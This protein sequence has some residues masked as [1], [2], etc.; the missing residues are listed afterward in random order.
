MASRRTGA[1]VGALALGLALAPT[2]TGASAHAENTAPASGL[3]PLLRDMD[4][5]AVAGVAR[6]VDLASMAWPGRVAVTSYSVSEPAHGS[7]VGNCASGACTYVPDEGHLGADEL[8]VTATNAAGTSLPATLRLTTRPN[9]PPT[10][11][12]DRRILDAGATLRFALEVSDDTTVGRSAIVIVDAPDH[13]GLACEATTCTYTPDPGFVG[14]DALQWQVDDGPHLS[15]VATTALVVEEN[16]P[17]LLLDGTAM[18][19]SGGTVDIPAQSSDSDGAPR[20]LSVVQPPQHGRI[21]PCTS[22]SCTYTA[23]PGYTGTDQFTWRAGD[24]RAWSAPARM[25]VTVRPNVAPRAGDLYTNG[26]EGENRVAPASDVDLDPLTYELLVPPRHGTAVCTDLCTWTPDQGFVGTDTF[27]YRASDGQ[28]WS[29]PGSVTIEVGPA[30]DSPTPVAYDG[31]FSAVADHPARWQIPVSGLTEPLAEVVTPPAH[32]TITGCSGTTCEYVPDDGYL[33]ADLFRWRATGSGSTTTPTVDARV[34]VRSNRTPAALSPVSTRVTTGA[35][36]RIY[37]S[38]EDD[39]G[40]LERVVIDAQPSHGSIAFCSGLV[41]HYTADAGYTGPDSFTWR[42]DDGAARSAPRTTSVEVAAP[43]ARIVPDTTV[44]AVAGRQVVVA[45][46]RAFPVT[47]PKLGDLRCHLT[48]CTYTA[49]P[50]VTGTDSFQVVS[51]EEP[52]SERATVTIRVHADAAPRIGQTRTMSIDPATPYHS[53]V[54]LPVT[55]P[56]GQPLQVQLVRQPTHGTIVTCEPSQCVYEPD[57]GFRGI[58]DFT[59]RATDG[60]T[61]SAV[62]TQRV[63]VGDVATPGARV[64]VSSSA[65]RVPIGAAVRWRATVRASSIDDASDVSVLWRIPTAFRIDPRSTPRGCTVRVQTVRCGIG[66][67]AVGDTR[68]LALKG[69]AVRRRSSAVSVRVESDGILLAQGGRSIL[70]TGTSCTEVGTFARDRIVGSTRDDV[71]CGLGGDDVLRGLGGDDVLL[72]GDG[73]DVLVGGSGRD[74][75][76]GGPGRDRQHQSGV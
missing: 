39:D 13:G 32:G 76:I 28:A 73:D 67:L 66:D 2:P 35:T 63:L 25:L 52:R 27:T 23:D 1:V 11:Y 59:W 9:L 8:V 41:C 42:A 4:G 57:P 40:P 33:G 17:P 64:A 62:A 65:R 37:F 51:A 5:P 69:V 24:G 12:D 34:V 36:R 46:D 20:N 70:A 31:S 43:S 38:A 18:V 22:D 44:D 48:R 15:R 47:L 75:L 14:A 7:L 53:W 30:S 60:R 74:R 26:F 55:D 6:G 29:G 72:G 49:A 3:A 61:L 19:R 71:L 56:E 68:E 45:L 58:D 54:P 21:G 10:V 16:A 50:T